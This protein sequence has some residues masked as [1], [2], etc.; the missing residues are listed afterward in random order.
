VHRAVKKTQKETEGKLYTI[1]DDRHFM[2]SGM[3]SYIAAIIQ[4]SMAQVP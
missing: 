3:E 1:T 2:G 4:G